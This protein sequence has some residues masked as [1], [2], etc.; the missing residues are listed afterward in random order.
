MAYSHVHN[1]FGS[2]F[3]GFK[4]LQYWADIALWELFLSERPSIRTIVEIGTHR[5]GMSIFFLAHAI[6]RD[7]VFWTFDKVRFPELDMP[8]SKR[9][10]LAEHF[11]LGDVFEDSDWR[12]LELLADEHLK[13]LML[14]VDGGNK[15]KE[16]QAFVPYLAPD[17]YVSV[18]DYSTEF[19]PCDVEPVEDLLEPVFLTECGRTTCLTRFWRRLPK[20]SQD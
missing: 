11:I 5:A 16:F 19:K 13:P 8:L 17:D 20:S 4:V 3:L 1:L 6:Q 14:F 15:P 9:L 2:T 7:M 12:L 10:G 18:H